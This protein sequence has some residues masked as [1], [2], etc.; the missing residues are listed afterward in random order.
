MAEASSLAST[1]DRHFLECVICSD[2]FNDP[3]ALPCMHPFCCECLERWAKSCSDDN[4][5]VS[6]P[7]CKKIYQIPEEEGIKGFPVHFLVTNLQDTVDK[8]KQN[9]TTHLCDTHG[10]EKRYFCEN[11]GCATCSDCSALDPSH[12]GHSFIRLKEASR[13]L[14]SSLENLTRRVGN[15]EE[16]YTTAIQQTQQVKQN[17]DQDT[18][19]KIQA[20]DEAMNEHMQQVD[21]LVR[22]CKHDAYSKKEQNVQKIE[23]TAEKLQVDLASLRSSNELASNVIESGS[24]SDII[25]LYPSLS[26]SL[27]QLTQAQPTPVD[28]TLGEIKLEPPQP[29]SMDLPSLEQLL[30]DKLHIT[31]APTERTQVSHQTSNV[32]VKPAAA[33]KSLPS[34]TAKHLSSSAAAKSPPLG[35]TVKS[36]QSSTITPLSAFTANAQVNAATASRQDPS[37]FPKSQSVPSTMP[38]TQP[39]TGKKWKECGQIKTTPKV[40]DPRGIAIHP[41][42][43][44]I[45]T[46]G[47]APVTV[48]S[49]NSHF[50]SW[51]GNLKHIIKGSPSNISDIA[52]TPS[53][54]YIIPGKYG[55][56][57]YYIYDSQGVLVSTIP[58]YDINN[59][60]SSPRSVAVDS[61]GR[62]I[63]ALGYNKHKTVSIHQP[64][65][66]LI[67]KYET[68]SPPRMLT[69]T[70]DDKLIISFDD[71]T[72]QVMDQSGHNASIIQPPPGIQSWRP[73][74]VCCSKQGELFVS[75]WG[76]PEDVYRY[77]CTG[78]EYK[79]L[80]CITRMENSPWG[81]AL[82]ADEQELFVVDCDSDTVKIFR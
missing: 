20:I 32:S 61:T 63:V 21:N 54:Q 1:I 78:G 12:R 27:Q 28:S 18:D 23:Q 5:I 82:S 11:C 38:S 2:T 60:P 66:T 31:V 33:A 70:P 14:S 40:M 36:P 4:S 75:N 30:C 37:L 48:F 17:L 15:V 58:T 35:S 50:L 8:A 73:V 39:S 57:E 72:L 67:S 24:D 76:K 56:N 10:Q 74:Y 65:G 44:I 3:R 9:S 46:S 34:A 6:C 64:D 19:A 69:C 47:F 81:I 51:N 26:S 49:R 43:D 41:N 55:K 62:I 22:A 79:Y 25:S 16:K 53:N 7:L 52:I 80:D 13:Q 71:D 77:V 59:Q 29:T 45:L 42:G 68:T